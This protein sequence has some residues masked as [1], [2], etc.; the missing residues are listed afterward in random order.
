MQPLRPVTLEGHDILL[1]L[2]LGSGQVLPRLMAGLLTCAVTVMITE[3]EDV[4]VPVSVPSSAVSVKMMAVSGGPASAMSD[5]VSCGP[6]VGHDIFVG[7]G[8]AVEADLG[9]LLEVGR[10]CLD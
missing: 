6:Q 8:G 2:R 10:S 5:E 7:V 9:T 3:S 4:A 1:P